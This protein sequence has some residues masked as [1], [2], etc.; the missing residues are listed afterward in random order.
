MKELNAI[1]PVGVGV[2]VAASLLIVGGLSPVS[3]SD[4]VPTPTQSIDA[5]VEV[6][7]IEAET[8]SEN[9][10]PAEIPNDPR[11]PVTFE[12]SP[13][14]VSVE[15]DGSTRNA[16]VDGLTVYQGSDGASSTVVQPTED[17]ARFMTVIGNESAPSEYRYELN[18]P[19]GS[20][21]SELP[22]GSIVVT[23][24]NHNTLLEAE[25]AWAIDAAGESIPTSYSFEDGQLV[26]HVDLDGAQ[27]PVVADPKFKN[28]GWGRWQLFFKKK[29]TQAI[30]SGAAAGSIAGL[31]SGP[32]AIVI[33]S[34]SA[35]IA[36]TAG[37]AV[38]FNQCIKVDGWATTGRVNLYPCKQ[39]KKL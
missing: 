15:T 20:I 38:A 21:V 34:L 10:S 2:A 19:D 11:I 27:F 26:Q 6:P 13:V 33:S 8:V 4:G 30:A 12:G 35:G 31:G 37:V 14:S 36:A 16:E 7:G 18:A 1:R 39:Y 9:A 32:A 23:D 3:A 25:P 29:E 24:E 17:G 22:D 28:N 5:I